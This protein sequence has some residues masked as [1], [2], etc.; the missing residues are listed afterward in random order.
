MITPSNEYKKPSVTR[1][2]PSQN[3]EPKNDITK[4]ININYITN[5]L[6]R[7]KYNPIE[8]IYHL[9]KNE[10]ERFIACFIFDKYGNYCRD[11]EFNFSIKNKNILH[12]WRGITNSK[13]KRQTNPPSK[14]SNKINIF[15]ITYTTLHL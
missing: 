5:K 6:Q 8:E 4:I 7:N 10:Q 12:V 1:N 9:N 15:Y 13:Q 2:K 14:K 3:V 11:H